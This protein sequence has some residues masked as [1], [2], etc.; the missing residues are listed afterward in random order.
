MAEKDRFVVSALKFRPQTFAEVTGQE[1]ITTT[2]RNA[3]RRKR[4]ANAFLFSGPRGVGKTSTA[5][6]L[7]KAIN[8]ENSQ[9]G[10]PCN[11]CT[12]CISVTHGTCLDVIELDAASNRGIDEARD[13][14]DNVRFPPAMCRYKVYIIDEAHQLTKDAF[15]ALLKTLEEPPPHA[16]FILATTEADKMLDTILSRCQQYRFRPLSLEQIVANL[17]RCLEE[18]T[19]ALIPDAIREE[20]LYLIARAS[21]GGMRDAQ[22]LFDQVA[23]LADES[24]TLEEIE[25]VLGGVRFDA[26]VELT[27]A[28]RRRDVLAALDLVHSIYNRGQDMA[29]LVRDLLGHFR[30]LMVAKSAPDRPELI[31]LPPDQSKS[32]MTQSVSLSMEDL[33]QGIDVLFEAERRLKVSGSPRAVCEAAVIKLAKLPTTVELDAL[34]GRGDLPLRSAA[35]LPPGPALERRPLEVQSRPVAPR[36]PAEPAARLSPRTEPPKTNDDREAILSNPAP[37]ARSD[38]EVAI[39]M[40]DDP[41]RDLLDT[42]LE[43]WGSIC[44][45]VTE[46]D[47]RYGG[48]LTDAVPRSFSKG[49]VELV[50]PD[51]LAFHYSQL[52]TRKAKD[53]LK[54]VL[55]EVAGTEPEIQIRPASRKDIPPSTLSSVSHEAPPPISKPA[56]AEEVMEAE[57]IVRSVLETFDG[58]VLEI[59]NN[60]N[61]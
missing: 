5:R 31:G 50:L 59:K 38:T 29:L 24:L 20:T 13:L 6:I 26:L 45:K 43:N 9:D 47:V 21:E 3:V 16:K 51:D 36:P 33:L 60:P 55:W 41:E 12:P 61:R 48:Y 14:R 58:V 11:K 46:K 7:A 19:S 1:H 40:D 10:E 53:I 54:A 44:H 23:S 4:L 28:I 8:C 25:L 57:P 39:R 42:L 22:S 49:V 18:Q 27:E 30:N 56:S 35:L 17:R 15:N 32:A 34:L 37:A 52:N 2:L